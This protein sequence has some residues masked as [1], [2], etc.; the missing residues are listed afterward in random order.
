MLGHEYIAQLYPSLFHTN[1]LPVP[2]I[3]LSYLYGVITSTH[4]VH[5]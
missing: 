5:W 1:T 4:M 2:L 3:Q